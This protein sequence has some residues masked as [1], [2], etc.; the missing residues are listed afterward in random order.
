MVHS[1]KKDA[2]HDF[3]FLG[4]VM[5]GRVVNY[6]NWSKVETSSFSTWSWDGW[7]ITADLS[8]KSWLFHWKEVGSTGCVTVNCVRQVL[9][10]GGG[11]PWLHAGRVGA[12]QCWP[13]HRT[14]RRRQLLR[15]WWIPGEKIKAFSVSVWMFWF[16]MMWVKGEEI[17][18]GLLFMQDL[19]FIAVWDEETCS[20]LCY[21]CKTCALLL[22]GTRRRALVCVF[23]QDFCFIAVWDQ[24]CSG[25]YCLCKTCVLLLCGMRR[26]V[27]VW[28]VYARLVFYCCVGWGDMFWSVRLCKTCVLLLCVVLGVLQ[29][30]QCHAS[31]CKASSQ[32][33][34][35]HHGSHEAFGKTLQKG[36]TIG[37]MLDLHDK[38]ICKST[39]WI[40]LYHFL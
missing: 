13:Q 2:I 21:L 33:R 40:C 8:L 32:A 38:T 3:I 20:G 19:C 35:W 5:I 39:S 1:F 26:H 29:L 34:K 4:S 9:W 30:R 10:G 16:Q 22:C 24:M 17:C 27:L 25:L 14:G 36:D 15:L 18:S 37:C 31:E 28:T 7:C 23:M 6:Q 11:D 12:G